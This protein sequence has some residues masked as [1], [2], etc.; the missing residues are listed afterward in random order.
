MFT[1]C[2]LQWCHVIHG[3]STSVVFVAYG[4]VCVVYGLDEEKLKYNRVRT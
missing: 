4:D 3:H 2:R 1:N